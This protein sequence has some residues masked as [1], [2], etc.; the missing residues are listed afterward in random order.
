MY[1][2]KQTLDTENKVTVTSGERGRERGKKR[3]GVG[4]NYHACIK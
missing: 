1:K 3:F 2:Q 4:G